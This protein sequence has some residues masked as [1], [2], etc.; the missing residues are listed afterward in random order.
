MH[1][2]QALSRDGG[3]E[4]EHWESS[5]GDLWSDGIGV[6]QYVRPHS[7]EG[8]MVGVADTFVVAG[9]SD[10]AGALADARRVSAE[11]SWIVRESSCF[12]EDVNDFLRPEIKA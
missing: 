8:T 10:G 9:E 11:G 7:V 12:E 6:R 1:E 2:D 3:S 5:A 4:Q